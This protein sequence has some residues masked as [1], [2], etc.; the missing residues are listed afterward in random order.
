MG[1]PRQVAGKAVLERGPR[2]EDGPEDAGARPGHQ[3]RAPGEAEPALLVG[4]ECSGENRVQVLRGVRE[5][6]RSAVDHA[7]FLQFARSKHAVPEK[8]LAE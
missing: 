5:Q 3:R 4:R 8:P 7:G 2:R 6:E 1:P